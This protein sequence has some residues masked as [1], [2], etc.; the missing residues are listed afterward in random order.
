ML[1]GTL[2]RANGKADSTIG[3]LNALASIEFDGFGSAVIYLFKQQFKIFLIELVVETPT[4][5]MVAVTRE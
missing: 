1:L 3:T 2:G 4:I 5:L